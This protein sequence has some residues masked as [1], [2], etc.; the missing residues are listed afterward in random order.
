MEPK[1]E[2]LELLRGMGVKAR[3]KPY[4]EPESGAILLQVKRPAHIVD[5]RLAGEQVD[6][7]RHTPPTFRVW[8]SHTKKAK[9]YATHYGLR[10]RMI[11]GECELFIPGHLADDLL[12][13]FGAKV[14]RVLSPEQKEKLL[15]IGF[16]HRRKPANLC[17]KAPNNTQERDTGGLSA[18]KGI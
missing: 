12:P 7:Y 13:K 8:T 2:L 1:G 6:L 18:P 9:A 11:D 3:F 5:G 17:F 16:Q 4:R 15:A 10:L 14:K